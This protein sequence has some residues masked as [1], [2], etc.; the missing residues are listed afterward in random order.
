MK[1][2]ILSPS[3]VMDLYYLNARHE[4]LEVAA[5]LD[6]LQRAKTSSQEDVSQDIRAGLLQEAIQILAKPS[7]T[8]DRAERLL[9]TFCKLRKE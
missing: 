9:N 7:E 2:K 8:P 3:E 4:L 6:R 5:T 1:A